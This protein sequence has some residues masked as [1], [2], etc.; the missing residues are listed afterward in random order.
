MT[1]REEID[2][3]NLKAIETSR[4]NGGIGRG[5]EPI[6]IIGIGCRFANAEGPVA[7]W[8]L[9]EGEDAT[10][11]VPSG[12]FDLDSVY[13][14][15]PATP[16]KIV[17]RR[18]GFLPRVDQFDPYFF[19]ISPREVARM[20]PQQRLLLEVSW[21]ALEDAGQVP[22]E[23]VGSRVGVFIGACSND[24]EAIQFYRSDPKTIDIY[25]AAGSA[26][27]ILAG[28]ISYALGFQGPSLSIDAACS[29]SLVA[30]HLACQSLWTGECAMALAGG[31]NLILVPEIS[32]GFSRAAMLAPD[33]RCKFGDASADGFV[34]SDGIG[35]VVLKPLS[36][37]QAD[38]DPVYAVILGCAV[39]NDGNSGGLLMTPSQKGQEAV[40]RE[41]Y[42][43]AGISPSAVQYVEAHGTGTSVG[44]PIELGALAAVLGKDRSKDRPCMLGSVKTNIGHTEGA[45][46]IAGLIKVALC[47]KHRSLVPSLHF[48]EP[49]PKIPWDEIPFRVQ[50]ELSDWPVEDGPA[51]AGVSSFGICGTNAHIVLQEVPAF[52]QAPMPTSHFIPHSSP[53]VSIRSEILSISAHT[54]KALEDLARAYRDF[55]NVD[56][57][58][59]E[60][61]LYDLCYTANARRTHHDHRLAIVAD[62]REKMAAGI[63]GHLQGEARA[64]IACGVKPQDFGRKVVFVFPGQGS[65][66]FGM[67]RRLLKQ[68]PVFRKA[69]EDCA[70]AI[71]EF[72]GW[73]LIEQLD[74]EEKDSRLNE[75]DVIQPTLFAIE[76]A[77]AAVWRSW[78]VE[79]D[80]VLGQSMGEVAACAVAGAISLSDAAKIICRRSRL[81]RRVSGQGAM[82]VVDLSLEQAQ[83]AIYR[84]SDRVSIAVSNSPKSTVL[85]GDP[86]ALE[87]ILENLQDRDVFCRLVKVDV[88]SHSPQ[89]D[90]L[91]ADLLEALDG[92]TSFAA[93]IPICSTVVGAVT[94]EPI[95]VPDYWVR[96]LREPVLFS[97]AVGQLLQSDHSIFIEMSPHP[98][99]LGAIQQTMH[100]HGQ[101]GTVLASFR[102]EEDERAVML[103]SL[104][105]LYALGYPVNWKRVYSE[106][107]Q[108]VRI[109]SYA[110][111]RES[112]WREDYQ[113]GGLAQRGRPRASSAQ[114]GVNHPILGSSFKSAAHTG[115]FFWETDID[116][117]SF[118]Y[119]GDHRVQGVVVLPAAAYLEMALAAADEVFELGLHWI[120]G[121]SFKK[122]LFLPDEGSLP[123]QLIVSSNGP[124]TASFQFFSR[125]GADQN[126]QSGWTLHASG[127]IRAGQNE[128]PYSERHLAIEE[129]KSRC[130]QT[131]TADSHYLAMQSRKL[132]YGPAFQGVELLMRHDG[133]ALGQ[134]QI[135]E[136]V[137]P[138]ARDYKVHPALLDAALQVVAATLTTGESTDSDTYLPVRVERMQINEKPGERLFSYAVLNG[139]ENNGTKSARGDVL[140]L[141]EDGKVAIEI[142]GLGMQR[143]DEKQQASPE[144]LDEWL[145]E[146]VWE[147]HPRAED[148]K[149]NEVVRGPRPGKWLIFADRCGAG[150]RL[151]HLLGAYGEKALLAFAGSEYEKVDEDRFTLNPAYGEGFTKLLKE[152]F[153]DHQESCLGVVYFWSLD[154]PSVEEMDLHSIEAANLLGCVGALHVVQAIPNSAQGNWP[155][156][157]LVTAGAQP[158]PDNV[159]PLAVE[160]SPLWGLGRVISH[161]QPELRCAMVDISALWGAEDI[162]SLFT[163]LLSVDREDQIAFRQQGRFVGRLARF[164]P[165]KQEAQKHRFQI[166]RESPITPEG[167]S[168]RLDIPTP[169][170]L[171]NLSFK[172]TP[173]KKLAPGEVEIQVLAVG[174]NF[175]DVMLAMGLLPPVLGDTIDLGWECAGL[176]SAVGE[177]VREFHI[178]QEVIAVAPPCFGAFA[179]TVSSLVVPKPSQIS[180]EEAATIPIAFITAHYA[181]NYL[182]RIQ[183]G[184][185]V[186]IHAAAGGVG[187]AA[188]QLAQR[189]EAEIFATAGTEE[190]RAFLKSLGVEHVFDSRSLGF[191]DE[192]MRLTDGVGV[193]LVLNS[194]A[195]EF[196]PRSLSVL[197]AGGR[198][199]EIGKVDILNNTP[200][201]LGF[202]HNNLS[203]FG[204]DLSQ[205]FLKQ[206]DFCGER[207][208]EVMSFFDEGTVRPLRLEAYPITDVVSAFRYMAQARHTGKVVITLA[209]QEVFADTYADREAGFGPEATYLITG[210]LGGLGLSVAR[211]MASHGARNIVLVGRSAPNSDAEAVIEDLQQK[212]IRVLAARADISLQQDVANLLSDIKHQ[213]PP[214]K[215][216]IHAAAVLDDGILVQMDRE[217][218]TSVMAPKINGAWNLHTLTEGE[219]LDF[220][221][222]FSSAA[223]LLGSPGQGNYSAANAFLD[224]FAHYRR[225]K[226]LEA[227]SINWGPWSEVGLAAR[228]DRGGRLALRGVG[229][230]S[231]DQ[232]LEILGQLLHQSAAQVCVMPFDVAQWKRFYPASSGLPL[233]SYLEQEETETA[234]VDTT[235]NGKSILT[236]E[237][238]VAALP[239]DRQGLIESYLSQQVSRVL[240]LSASRLDVKQPLNRMGL[241]SLMA[242]EL[243]NLVEGDLVVSLPLM[244]LLKGADVAQMATLVLEQ[245]TAG[246][247]RPASA[248]IAA[249]GQTLS[250]ATETDWEVMKL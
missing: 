3:Q 55:L 129:I 210:G 239:E 158:V 214:L 234:P 37:A 187:L 7:F 156:L 207:F 72:V 51:I 244:K 88:A 135:P 128:Q 100:H 130:T 35:V 52:S 134:L 127:T 84:Y 53:E 173:R 235:N 90:P 67:A 176:V 85:S 32:M 143:L 16:G 149:S 108:V 241:D 104:G 226:G 162:F 228:P 221:V 188:V 224:A 194:L 21:E 195:G 112:Y 172:A 125:D 185:R 110:W 28:R 157:W 39:N 57:T 6:A 232:G 93:S 97:G 62:S 116:V 119:L 70:D 5:T 190:K 148:L 36:M 131:T 83:E 115:T 215:G 233:F 137:R 140:L 60:P 89:M 199:L 54:S 42:R 50:K 153:A 69:L 79:P 223:S 98:I 218:F 111:Q 27:S 174:L 160:Q 120:E 169:G 30:T 220:F 178:G 247:D 209:D 168:F 43:N 80:A 96:N 216:V 175:R 237:K 152:N 161:E 141:N 11:D 180:F 154:A 121:V 23:W 196:I 250:P 249:V 87:D 182:G 10:G 193:N 14:P 103:N 25:A 179:K 138:G 17:T 99:L 204:I 159:E 240:G 45:A 245:V 12:R 33:G 219:Q 150:E 78:G 177:E 101:E 106:R 91:R 1:R 166:N 203:L 184:E 105:T 213:L 29:S 165:V 13:D 202:L 225:S 59:L 63:E 229:S 117:A 122:A 95:F 64:G 15:R 71:S 208:R 118:S 34:R 142:T 186:L 147:N 242:V 49:N 38:G 18:G 136:I 145:Y 68:E 132:E 4:I 206:P 24:Y 44:D 47:L 113:L 102:R 246:T 222:F 109:P 22:G 107:G 61:S 2:T 189:A 200:L 94:R 40:L 123:V 201:G 197:A 126:S 92:V 238:I 217:R 155:R 81:L 191:A 236:R 8:K 144:K 31:S 248:K 192:V 74:A 9:L 139:F 230:I 167:L 58:Q 124:G 205:M 212:G 20:D 164:A 114:S 77:L 66:W 211:W 146:L 86:K 48:R 231:P 46:G 170:I 181:L 171:D 26:R 198:F 227:L 163:E 133:E 19:G 243:K 41:A 82:A 151:A 75:I 56:S 76:V 73:S 183:K 65:Q